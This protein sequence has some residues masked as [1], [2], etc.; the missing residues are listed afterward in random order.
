MGGWVVGLEPGVDVVGDGLA[1]LDADGLADPDEEADGLT[2]PEADVNA[3]GPVDALP[4]E[5]V[6]VRGDTPPE[7]GPPSPVAPADAGAFADDICAAG[8]CCS[9]VGVCPANEVRANAV[10]PDAANTTPKTQPSTIGR[11]RRCRDRLGP[12][13]AADPPGGVSPGEGGRGLP[14]TVAASPAAAAARYGLSQADVGVPALAAAVCVAG[15]GPT[16]A[17]GLVA[18][19]D[20]GAMPVG[21]AMPEAAAIP[22]AAGPDAGAGPGVAGV[23]GV[24]GVGPPPA[25][26]GHDGLSAAPA[27]ASRTNVRVS[28]SGS[29]L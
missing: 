25:N 27:A 26:P 29:Q 9:G 11:S 21:G 1:D 2:D 6:P 12:S 23:A 4:G 19:P 8:D 16:T 22:A 28:E 7:A 17:S 3:D 10:A 14:G 20:G 13:G 24:T 18:A 15:S 5:V